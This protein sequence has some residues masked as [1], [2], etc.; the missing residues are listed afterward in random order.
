MFNWIKKLIKLNIARPYWN[1]RGSFVY[2]E[3]RVFFPKN[4]LIFRITT[5]SGIF[6]LENLQTLIALIKPNTEIFDIG[7]NIGMMLIP[8]LKSDKTITL[9][10]VEA[11]PNNIPYLK[12]THEHNPYKDR[13]TI[14]DK[15]VFDH[16]GKL[17]FHMASPQNG[18]YDSIH[19]TQRA[20]FEKTVEIECTTID[21]IWN[22]RNKPVVSCIKIDIEGADLLALKGGINCI[23]SCKPS[24]LMEWNQINIH[25]FGLGNKDLWDFVQSIN[26]T[27]Y[28]LPLLNK[29]L[30][31][32]DL[33]LFS[34]FTENFLLIPN[35]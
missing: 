7:A 26:Y 22:S 16:E 5:E 11:S 27:I 19:N 28:S 30:D 24:I 12:K 17:N 13:W 21:T 3:Q 14:I 35:Q 31:L 15:A 2:C 33:S 6:E 8:M 4:N 1:Y 32:Q 29:V 9:V 20:N 25:P 10:A 34:K 18:A 23:N